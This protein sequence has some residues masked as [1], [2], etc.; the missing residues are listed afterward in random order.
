MRV[1]PGWCAALL[2]LGLLAGCARPKPELVPAP[3]A[4]VLHGKAFA[5]V[6]TVEGVRV[7]VDGGA[8]EADP[9]DLDTVV[10]LQVKV[11]NHS[12]RPLRLRFREL[13]LVSAEGT[14]LAALPPLTLEG[15]VLAPEPPEPLDEDRDAHAPSPSEEEAGASR[16]LGGS[17]LEPQPPK[18]PLE[19]AFDAEGYD[20]SPTYGPIWRGLEAWAGPFDA[21]PLYYDTYLAQWPVN[22]P[23]EDMLEHALP[24]GVLKEDGEVAGFLFFQDVP[25]GMEAVRF[26]FDLVD[27]KTGQQFGSVSIPFSR[28]G[29]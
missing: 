15:R 18:E 16:G 12:G 24:E 11:E 5:A 2:G 4:E 7:Q 23:T 8:W 29:S 17:G 22:L 19:P 1:T 28:E 10:P 6:A 14:R 9:E 20:V 25:A 13:A 26:Q 3:S 27:A 21:D